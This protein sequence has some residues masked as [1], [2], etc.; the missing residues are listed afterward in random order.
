MSAG[1][2]I[3][4]G[5]QVVV[6]DQ[7][8]PATIL[9]RGGSI[10]AVGDYDAV[11]TG[12]EIIDAGEL[13]VMPGVVD[14][15]VHVN[16]PG[17]TEWEGFV[18]ATRA[19]A[20]GGVTALVDMPL[21]SIPATTTVAALD[22]KRG[23]ARGNT[24]IDAGFWGGVV[25]GN[26][27]QLAAMAR[28]GAR[29]FKC[30]LCPSGVDEFPFVDESELGGALEVLAGLA[31][32]L[33]V[34]AEVDGPIERATAGLGNR[35][36]RH[37]QTYLDS[38]PMEAEEEA[39]R[40]VV[41]QLRRTGG[42]AHIVHHS[43]ASALPLID[44]AKRD[45]LGLT[46]ETCPHY[47]HF[48]AEQIPD[49]AT[50][51]KCSPPIRGRDNRETL[52]SALSHGTLDMVASDHSPCSPQLKGLEQGDFMAAW[53]GISGLQLGLSVVWTEASRRG[54]QLTDLA[55]WMC[56]APSRLAGLHQ[57]KGRIAIGLDADFIFFDPNATF[58]VEG[59]AIAHRHKLTPYQG[60]T[61][62]GVVDTTYVR[63]QR[64]YQRGQWSER[65]LGELL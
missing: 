61:L 43:A 60:E 57:R 23:E 28:A 22:E 40:M 51:L 50:P 30:F 10:A 64:V 13:T 2:F 37:Y 35:D 6:G 16:Q 20:A 46:A 4:R 8:R 31:V 18:T 29:G 26:R 15:H 52:W 5:R 27:H 62:R 1:D 25:P 32:P 63:G 56:A 59:A 34:H 48:V 45:G 41:R 54:A 19:A 38:R 33:L 21:N 53:G 39:I 3:V 9:V 49:G 42:H 58:V 17:R 47:L 7:V 65:P 11:G 44:E 24:F 12:V 36:P 14:T 55:R